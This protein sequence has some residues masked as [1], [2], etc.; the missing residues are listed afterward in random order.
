MPRKRLKGCDVPHLVRMPEAVKAAVAQAA[1]ASGM[2]INRFCVEALARA[3][4]M[5]QEPIVEIVGYAW[6]MPEGS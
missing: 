5:E 4:G 1:K 3:A 6:K 2:S